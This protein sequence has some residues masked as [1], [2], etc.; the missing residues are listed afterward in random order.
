MNP[1]KSTA[2]KGGVSDKVRV[3]MM[4]VT[5][6]MHDEESEPVMYSSKGRAR[7]NSIE[8]TKS[9][10]SSPSPPRSVKSEEK[11]I[12][13]FSRADNLR[14]KTPATIKKCDS[15]DIAD[16]DAEN[17]FL[18]P[19][20][21]RRNSLLSSLSAMTMPSSIPRRKTIS[22]P[23]SLP[24][25]QAC[26]S[27][28]NTLTAG[29]PKMPSVLR[30]SSLLKKNNSSSSSFGSEDSGTDDE[31]KKKKRVVWSVA[32]SPL[33]PPGEYRGADTEDKIN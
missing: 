20:K 16:W 26:L 3:S 11:V 15:D 10:P 24:Q 14:D 27:V 13:S 29:A 1:S 30:L 32:A 17:S 19:V 12:S 33:I 23:P 25:K 2:V 4:T 7:A 5:R 8:R 21:P 18:K 28:Q 9:R 31:G 6:R 22:N